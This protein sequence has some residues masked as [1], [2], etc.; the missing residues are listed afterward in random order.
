LGRRGKQILTW[1]DGLVPA[2][3]WG[4]GLILAAIVVPA[5]TR[6]WD[7]QSKAVELRTSIVRDLGEATAVAI[8]NT[9]FLAA[10]ALPEAFAVEQVC[11]EKRRSPSHRQ[12]CDDLRRDEHLA[13]ARLNMETRTAWRRSAASLQA[14]VS[15]YF[16]GRE[17]AWMDYDKNVERFLTLVTSTCD[18][19]ETT[20]LLQYVLDPKPTAGA[21]SEPLTE[22]L[23]RYW[24]PLFKLSKD[25]CR[26]IEKRKAKKNYSLR[27][28][29]LSQ[30]LLDRRDELLVDLR[31]A[32]PAGLS[33]TGGDLWDDVR[34]AVP[35]AIVL[36]AVLAWGSF[37]RS[38]T[39][40]R[41]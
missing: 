20:R 4:L 9:R 8:S 6:Q 40:G 22:S 18:R 21:E 33:T 30:L 41:K 35:V 11:A 19:A 17:T 32:D 13:S 2:A 37:R 25:Q 26:K 24:G 5:I 14:R 23:A 12:R 27:V 7:E 34:L 38:G 10:L 1:L 29:E 15:T 39:P 36:L 16:P 31:D 28:V 3:A